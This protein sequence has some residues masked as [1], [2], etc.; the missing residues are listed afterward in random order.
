VVRGPGF[1]GFAL[2]GYG[3]CDT[4]CLAD[5]NPEAVQACRR[6]VV[7]ERLAERVAVYHSDNLDDIPASERWDLVVGNPPHFVD[8]SPGELRFHDEGWKLHR[9]F[10]AAIGRFLKPGGIIVL[11]ENNRGSTAETFRGMIEAVGLCLVFVHNCEGR[12]TPYTRTYYIGIARRGDIVPAW[13]RLPTHSVT[14]LHRS[15]ADTTASRVL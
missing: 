7:Q 10:F 2:L 1:I 13:A 14:D 11:L 4:L 6:T 9:R 3:F 8:I 12:R 5:V 15:P